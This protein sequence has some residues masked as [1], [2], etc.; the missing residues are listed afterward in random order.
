MCDFNNVKYKDEMVI[1]FNDL[2]KDGSGTR[3]D[4]I[5]SFIK[6][7]VKEDEV[8]LIKVL[9]LQ[10]VKK[11]DGKCRAVTAIVNKINDDEY[12]A[13]DE[14]NDLLDGL[15]NESGMD[16]FKTHGIMAVDGLMELTFNGEEE[17]ADY[18]PTKRIFILLPKNKNCT[19]SDV[20]QYYKTVSKNVKDLQTLHILDGDDVIKLSDIV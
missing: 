11:E 15:I 5:S 16:F 8:F 9:E 2:N 10:E 7:L 17:P 4:N 13:T 20:I 19:T 18:F 1:Y 14:V 12:E 3:E 6:P